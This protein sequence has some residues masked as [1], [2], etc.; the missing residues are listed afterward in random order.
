MS[1]WTTSSDVFNDTASDTTRSKTFNIPISCAGLKPATK[2]VFYLD[3]VV[4]GWATKP[5]G[6]KLGDDLISGDDGTLRFTFL[7]DFQFKASYAFDNLPTTP[8]GGSQYNQNTI[9]TPFY[10][11]TQRFLE[12]KGTGGA[13]ASTYFPLRTLITPAHNAGG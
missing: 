4:Y 1:L 3:G 5:F 13:Y 12:L 11:T 10:M 8:S 6:K 9:D 2:Y 7:Y